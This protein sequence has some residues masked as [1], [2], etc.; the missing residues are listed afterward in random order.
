[1][2]SVID[3]NLVHSQQVIRLRLGKVHHYNFLPASHCGELDVGVLE[4]EGGVGFELVVLLE[5]AVEGD[6][7]LGTGGDYRM[8][9]GLV[10]GALKT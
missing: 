4:L 6:E 1:M 5:E 2:L 10:K 3:T 9:Q 8:D 7:F